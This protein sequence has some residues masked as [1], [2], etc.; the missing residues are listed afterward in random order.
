[1]V[2]HW[3]M[4]YRCPELVPLEVVFDG[5]AWCGQKTLEKSYIDKAIPRKR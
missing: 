2:H 3:N 5:L 4:G 1:M